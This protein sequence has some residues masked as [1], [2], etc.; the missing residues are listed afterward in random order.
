M[1]NFLP[2][3]HIATSADK[4]IRKNIDA[5]HVSDLSKAAVASYV[6]KGVPSVSPII[7]TPSL[8]LMARIDVPVT[9][10][11]V[12]CW[13]GAIVAFNGCPHLLG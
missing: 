7:M 13:A 2:I 10:G 3:A 5:L 1:L 9:I 11:F 4:N 12:V 6:K 8:Y